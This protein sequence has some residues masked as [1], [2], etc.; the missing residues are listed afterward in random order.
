MYTPRQKQ[1]QRESAFCDVGAKVQSGLFAIICFSRL[2]RRQRYVGDR[3]DRTRAGIETWTQENTASAFVYLTAEC[4]IAVAAR[5]VQDRLRCI[6][7]QLSQWNNL[8]DYAEG[9][10]LLVSR[11]R[12]Q[13]ICLPASDA[14]IKSAHGEI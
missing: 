2:V 8:V 11:M 4:E 3:G 12:G 13:E 5:Y 9:F 14:R 7:R 10:S 1:R 6:G